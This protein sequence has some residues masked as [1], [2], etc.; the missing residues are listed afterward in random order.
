MCT[1]HESC[2]INQLIYYNF[3]ISIQWSSIIQHF[4][5]AMPAKLWVKCFICACLHAIDNYQAVWESFNWTRVT[6][7]PWILPVHPWAMLEE[8]P[9]PTTWDVKDPVNNGIN[10]QPQLVQELSHQQYQPF[11]RV[12]LLDSKT[13]DVRHQKWC[14]SR[15]RTA[16]AVVCRRTAVQVLWDRAASGDCN[17]AVTFIGPHCLWYCLAKTRQLHVSCSFF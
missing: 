5:R 15:W 13:W 4:C 16:R 3:K 8:I 14:T 1:Q 11:L 12:K 6:V 17:L 10:Y 7:H 2:K 9:F